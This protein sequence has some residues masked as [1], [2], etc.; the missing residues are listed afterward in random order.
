MNPQLKET[1]V[2]FKVET[3][4]AILFN[5]IGKT[6]A[7]LLSDSQTVEKDSMRIEKNSYCILTCLECTLTTDPMYKF[8][9]DIDSYFDL[10]KNT[11][12]FFI[13]N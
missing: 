1:V 6:K 9:T 5:R 12:L 7:Y 4:P 13:S 8:F 3:A 2:S 10:F 11:L